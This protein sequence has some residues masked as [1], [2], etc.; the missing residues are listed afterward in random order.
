MKS[1]QAVIEVMDKVI[2]IILKW[3][4]NKWL[5]ELEDLNMIQRELL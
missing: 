3:S 1:V 2:Q 5:E 4:L